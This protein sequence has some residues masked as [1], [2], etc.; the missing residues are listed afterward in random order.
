MGTSGDRVAAAGLRSAHAYAGG[1][2]DDER[3]GDAAHDSAPATNPTEAAELAHL[4]A[5]SPAGLAFVD[6]ELRIVRINE[7][8]AAI[9]GGRPDEQI[10][11][12]LRQVLPDLADTLE[13]IYR[14]VLVSGEPVSGVAIRGET[15]AIPG[16]ER[17]WVGTY[18]AV[19]S[20]SGT[21]V[22]VNVAVHETTAHDDM[23]ERE[24]RSEE[25][26]RLATDHAGLSTWDMDLT[27]GTI[28][29]SRSHFVLLGYPVHEDGIAT[30]EMW[31]SRIHPDDVQSVRECWNRGLETGSYSAQYRMTRVDDGSICWVEAHGRTLFD[32]DGR[33]VRS[34]GVFSDITARKKAE[35]DAERTRALL[36]EQYALLDVLYAS[37]PVGLCVFD[38]DRRYVRINERLAETNG[39]PVAAHI[40]RTVRDLLPDIAD[41][42]EPVFDRILATGEPVLDFEIVAETPARPGVVRTWVES[43]YPIR[44]ER[45]HVIAIGVVANEVTEQR[46]A[47]AEILRQRAELQAV[48]DVIPVGIAIAHD[49]RGDSITISPGFARTIGILP[50]GNV[51]FT[52]PRGGELARQCFRDGTA[53]PPDELPMQRVARTG[54]ELRDF[55]YDMQLPDGRILNFI[56]NVAP[57]LDADGRPCGAVG[58]HVDVTGLK[59]VQRALEAA[60]RQKNEFLAMLAHELRNPLAP[61]RYA[62]DM[63][64][65]SDL[66]ASAGE[67]LIAMV[68]R[69]TRQL[70]RLVDDLLDVSRITQKSIVLQRESLD[71]AAVVAEAVEGARPQFD[72]KRQTLSMH[73]ATPSP[74]V[75]GD[76]VRLVQCVSNLLTNASK[77]SDAGTHVDVDLREEQGYAVLRVRD[78]GAGIPPDLLHGV[79]DLFVQCEHT[80]DRARGGL[81]IGLSIVR[82]LVEM[83]GGTVA[84]ASEGAGRGATFTIRLPVS[85]AAARSIDL[86]PP[87]V[88]RQ[89]VYVVD[90]NRDA[91]DALALLLQIDGHDVRTAYSASEVLASAPSFEPDVMIMDIGLPGMDGY[92]L[93]QEVRRDP[94]LAQAR[95]IALTGYG[96]PADRERAREAGFDTHLTKPI[97]S[98][99]LAEALLAVTSSP[100]CASH[101]ASA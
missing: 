9:N 85:A 36:A 41:T 3:H 31:I 81:G 19:R 90:D 96:Q 92:R 86:Q 6:T 84:A 5:T 65:R 80:L 93:A 46:A 66:P 59:R 27:S 11:R 77:Y 37:A 79:F 7:T 28:R 33:P 4:Y 57:L 23:L 17:S 30:Y 34:V 88:Q 10:G 78:Q 74:H 58:A 35:L 43:W 73:V 68:Q 13:P 76:R 2:T 50:D 22:G 94:Q 16:R 20:S 53:I 44:D 61:I 47:T 87:R 45:Q 48:L 83:H 63:L 42:V 72:E 100:P 55:E 69:Q 1:P 64:T 95:I 70:A 39:A 98:G 56:C 40:G 60:D 99:A 32:R 24:R 26:L 8:L 38:R 101:G 91:A 14:S 18:S 51:S 52:G 15:A 62:A 25:R 49:A 71:L 54:Q 21:I 97:D 29:W 75:F 12:T 82:R 67:T 89:R